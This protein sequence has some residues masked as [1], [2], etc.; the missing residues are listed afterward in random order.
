MKNGNQ[1]EALRLRVAEERRQAGKHRVRFTAGLKRAVSELAST[2]DSRNQLSREL[3]L[4]S[5]TLDTWVRRLEV[6]EGAA[7]ESLS[8]PARNTTQARLREVTVVA[9]AAAEDAGRLLTLRFPSGACLALTVE[10]L[11]ALLGG[12]P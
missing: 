1:V 5:T 12:T 6:G 8:L 4:G 3:G 2:A 11:R 7:F 10:E 9:D